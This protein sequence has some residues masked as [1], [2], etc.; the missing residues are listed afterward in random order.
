MLKQQQGGRRKDSMT[1]R[2]RQGA[3]DPIDDIFDFAAA[4]GDSKLK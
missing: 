1:E 3:P 4:P 2:S